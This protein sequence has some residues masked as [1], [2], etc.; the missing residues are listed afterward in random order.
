MNIHQC[1]DY[2]IIYEVGTLEGQTIV[3]IWLNVSYLLL[4]PPDF[5][6]FHETQTTFRSESSM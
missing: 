1:F 5:F 2:S 6:L 4:F 3:V